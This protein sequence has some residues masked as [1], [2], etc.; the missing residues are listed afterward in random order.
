VNSTKREVGQS[1]SL[2]TAG[3]LASFGRCGCLWLVS[4]S[5]NEPPNGRVSSFQESFYR[6]GLITYAPMLRPASGAVV[7]VYF[8]ISTHSFSYPCPKAKDLFLNSLVSPYLVG[9]L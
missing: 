6:L 1:M 9:Q 3:L 7:N 2:F 5:F 4:V 8:T